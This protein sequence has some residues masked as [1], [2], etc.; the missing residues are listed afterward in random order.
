MI[1][2]LRTSPVGSK[3]ESVQYMRGIA[4]MLVVVHH[5][6]RQ[7]PGFA[8]PIEFIDI[9]SAGVMI[10]F[11]ISGFVIQHACRKETVTTFAARRFIRVVPLY[12]LLTA[13]YFLI[14]LRK[15]LASGDPFA[16][17]EAL[18]QS[19]LFLPHYHQGVPEMIWPL[20][21]PGW[22]LNYEMYFFV[23]FGIGIALGRPGAVAGGLLVAAVALGLVVD[24][25]DPRFLTW[26]SPILLLFLAGILLA[27]LWSRRDFAALLWL[28]PL[29]A[30]ALLVGSLIPFA[31]GPRL[32]LISVGAVLVM[33]GT[34]AFQDR[35]PTL[36]L[37]LLGAIGDASYSLYLSHTILMI[38]LYKAFLQ[39]PVTPVLRFWIAT[40]ITFAVCVAAGVVLFRFVEKPLLSRMRHWTSPVRRGYPQTETT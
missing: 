20:L 40:P 39:L 14:V 12:W 25:D 38:F 15:D 37:R 26:T 28:L 22:T 2:P 16:R 36:R 10:F 33:A 18:A 11:V 17:L 4:A 13:V 31:E 8:S 19:L 32:G 24:S 34:L 30:A 6:L 7:R 29:G 27:R 1:F 5:A 3:V 35:F 23:L 21:V 9:G